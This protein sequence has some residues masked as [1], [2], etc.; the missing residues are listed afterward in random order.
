MDI[1]GGKAVIDG[2]NNYMGAMYRAVPV[3]I[4]VEGANILTRN[5]MIYGQGAIRSH[6][7]MLEELLALSSDNR[8]EGLDHFDDTFW[9]HVGHALKTAGRAFVR[10]WS[11]GFLGPAP[12]SAAMPHHWKK[13]SRYSA[14]FALLSDFAL[15]T[16]GGSLKRRE[17]IS[18]RLGDILAELYLLGAVLKRYESEGRFAEDKPVVDYLMLEGE[19]RL[20]VAFRGVL[21]NLPARPAAWL[22]RLIAFPLGV[23]KPAPSDRLSSQLAE[24]LMKPSE[25]R[26]RLTPDL[27]L[28]QGHDHHPLKDLERAFRLVID[29]A[30]IEKKMRASKVSDPQ[31]AHDMDLITDGEFTQLREAQEAVARVIAV[32]AF[33]MEDISATAGQHKKKKPAARR[34]T[35]RR[36]AAE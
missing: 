34:K 1:H 12:E 15:L 2:P 25:Q 27:Y 16:L 22:V 29:A 36:Q 23:P 7:Y 4:T 20:G 8:E 18:A 17:M 19:A 31:E 28:G 5:L 9:K 33:P 24:I 13:L 21:D 11:G 6:P 35:P 14:A 10:G 30:P 3:G 32:D 26:D